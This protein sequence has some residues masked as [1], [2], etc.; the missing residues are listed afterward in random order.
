MLYTGLTSKCYI[1]HLLKSQTKATKKHLYVNYLPQLNPQPVFIF[2]ADKSLTFS[3]TPAQKLF[4]EIAQFNDLIEGSI[5]EIIEHEKVDTHTLNLS[6]GDTYSFIIRG[7]NELDGVVVYGSD[8]SEVIK[9]NQEIHDTQKEIIY[10]MGEIGETR[11][12]ET[13]DHVRR[14]AEYSE[15]LAKLCGLDCHEAELIKLASPMHDIGKVGIPDSI[16]KKPGK[17]TEDEFEVMK[18]HAELGYNLLN[19]ST[20]PV[21]KALAIIA[22]HHHEKWN[23]SGY[24]QNLSG[25]DIHIYGRITAVADVFDAL[26][27]ERVY[28][29]AWPL[30]KILALFDEQ[31]G[32]H[33][34]PLLVTLMKDNLSEF[35]KIRDKYPN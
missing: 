12:K 19:H 4:P 6:N 14:V 26:G 2:K 7:S 9:L 5:D 27:D 32:I 34:D 17:L 13:G 20:R 23:G 8:I 35:L 10:T 21:L 3:N 29:K 25:E 11:S 16:L 1:T 30:D 33:F 31:K 24:P 28:K 22:Y 15:L 18:T